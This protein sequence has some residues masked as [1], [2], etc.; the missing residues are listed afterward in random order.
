MQIKKVRLIY[1][2]PTGTSQ[3]VVEAIGSGVSGAT[4]ESINLTYPDCPTGQQLDADELAII[5]VPVY[6]GRVAAAAVERL[7]TMRGSATPAIIV[8]LYGNR[9]YE[10]A[11]IELKDIAIANA[12]IPV[13]AAAFIGEHS[14]SSDDMPIAAGRPDANDL[15]EA[16]ELGVKVLARLKTFTDISTLEDIVVPGNSTYIDGM[17]SLP[18]TPLVDH[19]VCT[20]CG[21]CITSCPSGAITL[22]EHIVMESGLCIFCCACIKN[23]PE[24][25][26]S[27]AAPPL[28]EKRKW[29]F[30]NCH[31]RK[32]PLF[33][34]S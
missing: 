11:L 34:L 10:D 20:D 21:L 24:D 22:G 8:V 12:F 5:G 2:S 1:F 33:F 16:K 13:A 29:L 19:E 26:V 15:Q 18:F 6:A 9:E 14:F 27:I 30:E 3:K 7:K 32:D 17:G 25:A 31:M 28:L 4:L 23:C